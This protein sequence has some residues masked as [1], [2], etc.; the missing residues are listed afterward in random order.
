MVLEHSTVVVL[1]Q[2][3]YCLQWLQVEL[4]VSTSRDEEI[5]QSVIQIMNQ[6]H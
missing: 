2:P 1:R 4:D 5:R 6:G 3:V